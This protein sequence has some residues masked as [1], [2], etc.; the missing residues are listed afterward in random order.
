MERL[1]FEKVNVQNSS[2]L[3]Y[4]IME[5]KPRGLGTVGVS[6]PDLFFFVAL[7]I[8]C[9]LIQIRSK[10]MQWILV[11]VNYKKANVRLGT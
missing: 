5:L 4:L 8:A 7:L 9:N 10:R 11:S 2:R 1:N 3:T 6:M